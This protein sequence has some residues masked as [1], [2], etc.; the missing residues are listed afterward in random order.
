VPV[1]PVLWWKTT[2][3]RTTL[4]CS[5]SRANP[6][7]F[8]RVLALACYRHVIIKVGYFA[9][10]LKTRA[11]AS[12]QEPRG[13]LQLELSVT[14]YPIL[15]IM[16]EHRISQPSPVP[17]LNNLRKPSCPLEKLYSPSAAANIRTLQALRPSQLSLG[18][19]YKLLLD[20]LT[21]QYFC[22]STR[23]TPFTVSANLFPQ[24][25]LSTPYISTIFLILHT[26]ISNF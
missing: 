22:L 3:G 24:S 18:T 6:L 25:Y 9:D 4:R 11:Q 12:T 19:L 15:K 20:P 16:Y 21:L 10:D 26:L 5:D 2:Q 1:Y 8:P 17:V 23:N 14:R 13:D 7:P